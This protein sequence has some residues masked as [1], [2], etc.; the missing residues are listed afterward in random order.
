MS[1]CRI[2]PDGTYQV[3][4]RVGGGFTDQDR[5]DWCCDLKD[6]TVESDHVET[7]MAWLTRWSG[8]NTSSKS[9]AS[10]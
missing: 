7:N 1:R 2:R 8:P 5:R 3:L 6:T 9:V 4:G 10:T